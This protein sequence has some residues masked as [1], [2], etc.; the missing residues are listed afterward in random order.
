MIKADYVNEIQA[1]LTEC[2]PVFALC[3]LDVAVYQQDFPA[4]LVPQLK[5]GYKWLLS[6]MPIINEYKSVRRLLSEEIWRN[7]ELMDWSDEFR[8]VIMLKEVTL[9][10]KRAFRGRPQ[11]FRKVKDASKCK[12]L[13]V[14]EESN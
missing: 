13:K 12:T 14:K 10:V 6:R 2:G 4:R 5:A 9:K 8:E 11:V 7:Y 3:G 1:M